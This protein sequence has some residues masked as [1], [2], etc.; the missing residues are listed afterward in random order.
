MRLPAI[1][2]ALVTLVACAPVPTPKPAPAPAIDAAACAARG[3]TVTPVCRMQRPMCVLR[4]SDAGK[5]CT[6]SDQCQG[7]CVGE[8]ETAT[9]GVCEADSDPCGCTTEI[10]GGKGQTRCVD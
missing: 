9:V 3:G 1:L 6:D 5:A 2:A 8:D 10:I 4:Y 7:R